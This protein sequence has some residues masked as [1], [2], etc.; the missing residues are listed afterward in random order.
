MLRIHQCRS[1][2]AAQSYFTQGLA[3]EDYYTEG[4]EIAG[5][6][7]GRAAERLGLLKYHDG[8]VERDAF[9]ALT[10]N[11]HPRTG[12]RLTLRHKDN[13]TVGYD[14]NFHAP[15][16][17]SLLHAVHKDS[18]IADA[19]RTSVRETMQE[20]ERHAETR[21]R[22][23]GADDNRLTGNLVWADFVHLTARPTVAADGPDPHLHAHCFVMNCTWDRAEDS[24][25]AG[26]FRG[27][28]RDAPYYEA[29]FHARFARR[30]EDLGYAIE[31]TPTGWDLKD[32]PRTLV[33]K[34]STRTVEIEA[35]AAEKG[36]TDPRQKGELG[37][38]TRKAKDRTLSA[39]ELAQRWERRLDDRERSL[40]RSIHDR[41]HPPP[42]PPPSETPTDPTPLLPGDGARERAAAKEA[43][44]HAI[45]HCFERKSALPE[46]RLVEQALRFGVGRVG[47]E[48]A[49]AEVRGRTM[50]S[51][52]IDG[53]TFVTTREVLAQERAMLAFAVGGKG[54]CAPARERL[55]CRTPGWEPSKP[56]S[57]DQQKAV[58]H[59]LDSTDRVVAI[60]GAAGVGKTTMTLEAVGALRAAGLAVMVVAPTAAASRGADGL[61]GKG[62]ATA[63]T[64][65]KLL[66]D[67]KMQAGLKGG[68]LW[69]D[70]AGLLG[71]GTMLRLSQLAD[72]HDARVV[73][74]GDARQH[75]PVEAGDALRV[76]ES[77]GGIAPVELTT[78]RRQRGMYREA[79]AAI[80]EGN[81][82]KG[83]DRLEK[84]NAFVEI[85]DTARRDR[86]AAHD[87]LTALVNGKT[88]MI[89]SPTHAEGERVAR[90]V[91]EAQRESGMLRGEDREFIRL[92]DLNWSEAQRADPAM[93]GRDEG[94]SAAP[95]LV[96][97]FHQGAKGVVAGDRCEILGTRPR[98]GDGSLAVIARTPRGVE[99][100]LPIA[101]ADRFQVFA[102]EK[103]SLAAGDRIRVTRNGRLDEGRSRVTNGDVCEVKGFT[104]DGHLKIERNGREQTLPRGYGHIAYGSVS[105]SHAAQGR[106][107]DLAILVQSSASFAA[108]SDAQFYV[109][110]SRGK[111][112]LRIYTDDIAEL[113][114]AIRRSADRLSAVEVADGVAPKQT[115]LKAPGRDA[116]IEKTPERSE[117]KKPDPPSIETMRDAA[118]LHRLG[119]EARERLERFERERP[120]QTRAAPP[121]PTPKPPKPP[122]PSRNPD[123]TRD[124]SR[125]RDE[126]RGK[127]RGYE[128]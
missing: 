80:A 79:V 46:V 101:D 107:V 72:Q 28:K 52:T 75:R 91:R 110:V 70:E 35:F 87:Y 127:E 34:Y 92:R 85:D 125:R 65:A 69:V 111:Q 41:G 118:R 121:T 98:P 58:D 89:V 30:L 9:A 76:L 37:A 66:S 11:R 27:I 97:H 102:Q 61:R 23:G 81:L 128:R 17:V 10:E 42:P 16:G 21:V 93:Y 62:L 15:K 103:I 3:R 123:H 20:I 120:P 43:V 7:Q 82:D 49:W 29:A 36:I 55:L 5:A 116:P 88:A 115:M 113:K 38:R 2:A 126:G 39:A 73:V 33:E 90:A 53:Q 122:K 12:E 22:K 6:W 64:V 94:A 25:K 108:G 67:P 59:V 71:V 83:L 24:W 77:H 119:R 48:D 105:T 112:G 78:I 44:D 51:R 60:R 74:C 31:R 68:V 86:A 18:R 124:Q 45:A 84:L 4:L 1:A 26:Q 106:D 109:S 100:E 50:L 96:A 63:D 99:I 13:R 47:V 95:A 117:T 57:D 8:A 114:E 104:K 14:M 40:L 56:L 32:I 19:F 54:T